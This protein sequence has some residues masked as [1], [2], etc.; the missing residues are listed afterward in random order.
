[1][2]TVQTMA[3]PAK[4]KKVLGKPK[5]EACGLVI[6]GEHATIGLNEQFGTYAGLAAS[7]SLSHVSIEA[8][9]KPMIPPNINTPVYTLLKVSFFTT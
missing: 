8:A 1:M 3:N 2:P 7:L 5:A 9:S 6:T 4:P